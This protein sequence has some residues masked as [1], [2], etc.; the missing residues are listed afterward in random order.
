[1]NRSERLID[2]DTRH[3]LAAALFGDLLAVLS[4]DAPATLPKDP[5]NVIDVCRLRDRRSGE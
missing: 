5:V 2:R 3:L 1:M 4:G